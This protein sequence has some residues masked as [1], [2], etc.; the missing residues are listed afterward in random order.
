M[1]I[2]FFHF[3]EKYRHPVSGVPVC[4]CTEEADENKDQDYRYS[5]RQDTGH[6]QPH[7]VF[8][9]G[10]A[11]STAASLHM[12]PQFRHNGYS[13]FYLFLAKRRLFSTEEQLFFDK[14]S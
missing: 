5:Q 3:F 4:L 2:G 14:P 1:S 7:P 6:V 8:Q 13:E 10:V 9:L 11:V 12:V